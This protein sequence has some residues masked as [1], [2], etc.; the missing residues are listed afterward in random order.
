MIIIYYKIK[1]IPIEERPR[2]RL[3][4]VGPNNLTDKELLSIIIKT[5]TKNKNASDIALD[6]LK[7]YSLQDLQEITISELTKI[8]GIGEVKALEIISSIELG[9]RIFL[10]QK[11]KLKKLTNPNDVWEDTR[12]L[13]TNK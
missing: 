12:Y 7:K 2:E 6:I 13:F 1:D 10:K 3:K 9:K 8:T 4:S 5:G 11:N